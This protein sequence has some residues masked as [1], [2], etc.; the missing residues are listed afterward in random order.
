M[1]FQRQL[2]E[3]ERLLAVKKGFAI[4]SR[5]QKVG[6]TVPPGAVKVDMRTIQKQISRHP[7]SSSD[8]A[9][10]DPMD[11]DPLANDARVTFFDKTAGFGFGGD[12]PD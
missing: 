6:K 10:V 8:Y 5:V 4:P 2:V 11:E 1:G 7:G 9:Y 3:F 12:R